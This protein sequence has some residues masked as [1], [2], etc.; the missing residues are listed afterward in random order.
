[1]S[2]TPLTQPGPSRG[3][4]NG[5]A[6]ARRL[7]RGSR[8]RRSSYRGYVISTSKL[9]CRGTPL[10]RVRDD[11]DGRPASRRSRRA[12]GGRRRPRGV[13]SIQRLGF[14]ESTTAYLV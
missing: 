12:R 11:Y 8:G 10:T 4:R 14:A 5:G 7:H 3:S 6:A 13:L 1:M 9:F 2:R